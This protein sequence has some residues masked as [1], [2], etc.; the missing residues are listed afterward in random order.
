MSSSEISEK[1]AI[2]SISPQSL[3]KA[4]WIASTFQEVP[5]HGKDHIHFVS[6]SDLLPDYEDSKESSITGYDVDLMRARASL[7][8]EEEKKLLRQVDW[9]LLPLLAVMYAVK[10]IDFQNV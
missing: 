4:N 2:P 10:T 3:E 6:R 5:T 1:Q 7:S 9:R 8:S